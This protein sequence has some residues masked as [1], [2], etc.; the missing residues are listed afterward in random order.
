MT[1]FR[2]STHQVRKG[3]INQTA[4]KLERVKGEKKVR[5]VG[6]KEKNRMID[7]KV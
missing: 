4:Q 6:E 2:I 3:L 7:K 5:K 1:Y